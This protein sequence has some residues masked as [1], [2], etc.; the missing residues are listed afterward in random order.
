MM[1]NSIYRGSRISFLPVS[2]HRCRSYT[3]RSLWRIFKLRM[4]CWDKY[5][6]FTYLFLRN[7]LKCHNVSQVLKTLRPTN[8]IINKLVLKYIVAFFRN[9]DSIS[10]SV[11]SFC[12]QMLDLAAGK[13]LKYDVMT[14]HTVFVSMPWCQLLCCK[15]H[16]TSVPECLLPTKSS[17]NVGKLRSNI[18]MC[19]WFVFCLCPQQPAV[20]IT[21]AGWW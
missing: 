4:T 1:K 15:F 21:T 3:I 2:V 7:E 10:K 14:S 19:G 5:D 20:D 18:P 11:W 16:H 17:C 12:W 9:E 6:P 8:K 13:D